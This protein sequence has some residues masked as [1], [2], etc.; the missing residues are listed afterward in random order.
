M[1]NAV[2]MFVHK[3]SSESNIQYIS[4]HLVKRFVFVIINLSCLT[5]QTQ[6]QHSNKSV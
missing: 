1:V 3:H 6:N 2:L 5:L 4:D